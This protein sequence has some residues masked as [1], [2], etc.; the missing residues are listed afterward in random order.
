MSDDE[1]IAEMAAGTATGAVGAAEGWVYVLELK[2]GHWY[3]GYSKDPDTRI[4]SH[5]LGRGAHWT[6]LHPPERVVSLQPGDERLEN[7]VTVALMAKHGWRQVRGGKYVTVE[8]HVPPPPIQ[9]AYA[10]KPPA[11]LPA[12]V[13]VWVARDH[14]I[15]IEKHEVEGPTVWRAKHIRPKGTVSVP[16]PRLQTHGCADGSSVARG[17]CQVVGRTVINR[18]QCVHASH[19]PLIILFDYIKK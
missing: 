2:G 7:V 6:R 10:I 16:R 19:P 18:R 1:D 15:V 17:R 12:Q 11:P 3:V 5:F 14:S 8:M 4:A 9:K 13:D